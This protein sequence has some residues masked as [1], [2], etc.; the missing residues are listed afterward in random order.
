MHLGQICSWC[1]TVTQSR[2]WQ[3]IPEWVS[4]LCRPF[5]SAATG[6]PPL[7]A[8]LYLHPL[9]SPLFSNLTCHAFDVNI[10]WGGCTEGKAHF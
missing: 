9:I 4:S 6:Y 3:R 8:Y 7:Q 1:K 2:I 10:S 5:A